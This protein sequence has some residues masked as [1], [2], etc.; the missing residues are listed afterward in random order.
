MVLSAGIDAGDRKPIH[1]G[2]NS[3]KKKKK[4][5]LLQ[6]KLL[7]SSLPWCPKVR[8]DHWL[9]VKLEDPYFHNRLSTTM[10]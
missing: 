6:T 1:I 5:P 8:R 9:G 2:I 4:K 10:R 7:T 3:T